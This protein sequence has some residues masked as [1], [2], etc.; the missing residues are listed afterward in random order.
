MVVAPPPQEF[1]KTMRCCMGCSL[2]KTAE[3]FFEQGCENCLFLEI[4]EDRDRVF[5]C[6]T[7]E[8]QVVGSS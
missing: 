2:I 6:T 8:F 5:D 4:R 3:Q 7:S 1:G